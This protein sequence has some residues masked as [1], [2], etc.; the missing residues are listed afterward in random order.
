M[1]RKR[2]KKKAGA[3]EL[4]LEP[5]ETR[6]WYVTDPSTNLGQYVEAAP[7]SGAPPH[8]VIQLGRGRCSAHRSSAV[9][10]RSASR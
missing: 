3:E 8:V 2:V 9:R 4:L 10:G 5:P 7:E 6:A 1:A